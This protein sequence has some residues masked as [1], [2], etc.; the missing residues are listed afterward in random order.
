MDTDHAR[1]SGLEPAR[2]PRCRTRRDIPKAAYIPSQ[3]KLSLFR[4]Q[5]SCRLPTLW[6]AIGGFNVL[7]ISSS[8]APR[9]RPKGAA[10]CPADQQMQNWPVT[11]LIKFRCCAR[12]DIG[13][14]NPVLPSLVLSHN[15]PQGSRHEG[16][17]S[18]PV[19]EP[20]GASRQ[21]FICHD[22]QVIRRSYEDSC[23]LNTRR[24]TLPGS[25]SSS[26]RARPSRLRS[27]HSL[28]V[29]WCL[30]IPVKREPLADISGDDACGASAGRVKRWRERLPN[31]VSY[32]RSIVSITAGSTT[33]PSSYSQRSLL[34]V[35]RQ[36][37]Q[38]RR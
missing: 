11:D 30:T 15:G 31:G 25:R 5:V 32:V 33:P 26:A 29:V 34:C 22:H 19:P 24:F 37:R 23:P 21:R 8:F 4:D 17:I 6:R 9:Q 38:L 7:I 13:R 14:G 28:Y 27:R 3:P 20:I 16:P 2:F 18:W 1:L 10:F 12:D 36:P 35:G